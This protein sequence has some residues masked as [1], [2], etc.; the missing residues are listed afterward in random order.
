MKLKLL[1]KSFLGLELDCKKI[2]EANFARNVDTLEKAYALVQDLDEVKSS[3]TQ[4]YKASVTVFPKP[5]YIQFFSTSDSQ[6]GKDIERSIP[7]SYPQTKCYKCQDYGHIT[8]KCASPYKIALIDGEGYP[9]SEGDEYIHQVDGD[10]EDF[11][12]NTKETMLNCLRL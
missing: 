10:E 4:D 12:K 2:L 3:K 11:D 6:E 9:Q 7:K 5:S 8:A 1:C